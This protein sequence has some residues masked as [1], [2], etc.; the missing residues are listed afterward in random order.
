VD[1]V[2][3]AVLLG[4]AR[5]GD[6]GAFT[7][8]YGRYQ[9][10]IFRYASH[11]C[12]PYAGD[13]VVQETFLAVL[14]KRGAFDASKGSVAAYLFGI[15]RHF[16]I[17]H[18]GSI[19]EPLVDDEDEMPAVSDATILDDL[20]RAERVGPSGPRSRNYRR[21][22]VRRSCSASSRR[23]TTRRPPTFWD[24]QSERFVPACI[25]QRHFWRRDSWRSGRNTA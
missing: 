13:D 20:T 24:V 22:F 19:H 25:E 15:A 5:R 12:G 7:T 9:R 8:L 2:G 14:G 1:T 6:E 21:R 23:S 18:L 16:V 11:M 10:S 3:D 17:K 4:L